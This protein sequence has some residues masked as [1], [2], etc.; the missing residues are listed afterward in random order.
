MLT[1]ADYM[2]YPPRATFEQYYRA[3]AK[4]AGVRFDSMDPFV[5]R[6]RKSTDPHLNDIPL[7]VWDAKAAN[8]TLRANLSRALKAHGDCLSAAGAVCVLKQAARDA[9][10]RDSLPCETCGGLPCLEGC[11]GRR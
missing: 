2:A 5:D 6:V 4:T 10:N 7:H 8:P 11:Q 3:V 9:A 1:R